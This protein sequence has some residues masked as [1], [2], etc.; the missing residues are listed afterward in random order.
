[1]YDLAK[2]KARAHILEGLRIAIKYLDEVI[3]LIRAA[4]DVET[5]RTRL[6]KR[7]SLS[8]IQANAILEMPPRRLAALERKKIE[9]EYKDLVALIKELEVLLKSPKKMR[10]VIEQELMAMRAAYG[11]RRRTQIVSLREGEAAVDRLTAT[12]VTP[13]QVVWV[14][15]TPEGMIGRT[16]NDELPRVSGRAAPRFLLR[17]DTHQTLYLVDQDGKAA[18]IALHAL[19]E[20]E[21]FG[22]GAP[23]YKVS[24]LDEKSMLAGMFSVPLQRDKENERFVVAVTQQGMVKKTSVNDLPGPS[25]QPFTLMKVDGE[26][27]LGWTFLTRG[28]DDI[29][30]LTAR[31]MAIRF[32]EKE[33]RPMGLVAGGVSGIKLAPNDVVCAAQP[34]HNGE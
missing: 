1:E 18:A 26:D 30:L 27:L 24:S 12:D 11:D 23:F 17:A 14:G 5:A 19:P 6:M 22:D 13:A 2:A 28:E 34:V 8:E 21:K 29:L 4:P 31:G 3:A 7:F 25:T 9:D 32:A 15:V 10:L 16:N 33:V 20:V